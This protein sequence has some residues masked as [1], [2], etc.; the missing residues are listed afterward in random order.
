MHFSALVTNKIVT[1]TDIRQVLDAM[2]KTKCVEV[3]I[4]PT[5]HPSFIQGRA[6]AIIYNDEAIGVLGEIHP[7]VLE[8][9]RLQAPV[10]AFEIN[11]EKIL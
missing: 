5:N 11:L 9:F 6:G 10:A 7:Q 1:F 3:T 2:L 4:V 8:N